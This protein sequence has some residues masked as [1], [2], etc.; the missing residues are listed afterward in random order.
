M[1][2]FAYTF[3]ATSGLQTDDIRLYQ[4]YDQADTAEDARALAIEKF[5]VAMVRG[6]TI[7]AESTVEFKVIPE[8]D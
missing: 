8:G 7:R 4:S 2:C 5:L 1:T 3:T 6:V